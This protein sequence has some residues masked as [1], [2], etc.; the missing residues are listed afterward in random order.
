MEG[1][2]FQRMV[3]TNNGPSIYCI[4]NRDENKDYTAIKYVTTIRSQRYV[5]VYFKYEFNK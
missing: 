3:K 5:C 4:H 2:V 1:V